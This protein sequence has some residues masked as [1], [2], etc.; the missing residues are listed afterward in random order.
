M[1]PIRQAGSSRYQIGQQGRS[2]GARYLDCYNLGR[3]HRPCGPLGEHGP[4]GWN[5]RVRRRKSPPRLPGIVDGTVYELKPDIRFDRSVWLTI[6]YEPVGIPPDLDE[7]SLRLYELSGTVWEKIPESTVDT[8]A[9]VVQGF[10]GGLGVYGVIGQSAAVLHV[11]TATAGEDL[12]LDCYTVT[13]DGAN[14]QSIGINGQFTF[15]DL[16]QGNH[17]VQLSD[18]A[19]NCNG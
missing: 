16:A 11:T 10:I 9:K 19:S 12:D 14:S 17:R 15:A 13:V 18:I 5:D 3:V 6:R 1:V 7:Q 2:D 4:D 8:D